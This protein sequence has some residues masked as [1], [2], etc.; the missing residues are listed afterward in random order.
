MSIGALTSWLSPRKAFLIG[1]LVVTIS[2]P[3]SVAFVAAFHLIFAAAPHLE[4]RRAVPT[5]L[6]AAV[7]VHFGVF[8]GIAWLVHR[9]LWRRPNITQ[10][11][12]LIIAAFLY[13]VAMFI[14]FVMNP[15][16][17]L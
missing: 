6:V 5:A 3:F 1:L 17:K 14:A 2:F 10:V 12:A 7:L 9:A 8:G 4:F 11:K 16:G 13:T 15:Y